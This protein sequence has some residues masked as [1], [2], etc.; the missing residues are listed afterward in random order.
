MKTFFQNS[1]NLD[2]EVLRPLSHIL[3]HWDI[4]WDDENQCYLEEEGS[5]AKYVNELIEQLELATPPSKYHD[6]EDRLAEYVITRL[7]WPLTKVNGRW[8]GA[9]YD[10]I[11]EQGGFDDIDQDS[12]VLAAA[13]RIKAAIDRKQLHFDD[14][15]GSHRRMLG[16]VLSIILYHR[17]NDP[18]FEL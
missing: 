6:N 14:M 4:I 18:D 8:K 16:A 7:K 9:D 1:G 13:G 15:E 2:Y 3:P 5:F 12:L 10:S 11:L 17:S